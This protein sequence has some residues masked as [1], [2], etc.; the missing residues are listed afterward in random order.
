MAFLQKGWESLRGTLTDVYLNRPVLAAAR[1]WVPGGSRG[2]LE[3]GER[4]CGPAGERK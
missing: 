1:E 2:H 4:C 3:A